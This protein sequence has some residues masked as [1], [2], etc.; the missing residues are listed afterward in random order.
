MGNFRMTTRRLDNTWMRAFRRFCSATYRRSEFSS[1]TSTNE[2]FERSFKTRRTRT[3]VTEDS[4]IV[5]ATF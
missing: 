1:S 5:G 4:T 2:R 3:S